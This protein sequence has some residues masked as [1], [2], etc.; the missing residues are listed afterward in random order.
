M[1]GA[2]Q[3]QELLEKTLKSELNNETFKFLSVL[4]DRDRI[5][6]LQRD[7]YMLSRVSL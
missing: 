5:N 4:V 1:I 7:Y 3:K 2:D 6:L